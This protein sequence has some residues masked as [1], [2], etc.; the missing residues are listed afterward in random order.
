MGNLTDLWR[1]LSFLGLGV[2]CCSSPC[3]T[4]A[5]SSAS[6]GRRQALGA[7][8]PGR[9]CSPRRA[10]RRRRTPVPTS[11]PARSTSPPPAVAAPLDLA[12]LRHLGGADPR[13]SPRAAGGA[14]AAAARQQ[15]R[16]G[17]PGRAG[18]EGESWR[19][20]LD[21]GAEPPL[22]EQL[23]F[24]LGRVA[25]APAVRLEGSDERATWHPLPRATSSAWGART[26]CSAPPSS[27]PQPRPLP[28]VDLAGRGGP[29]GA[30]Q[31]EVVGASGPALAVPPRRGLPAAGP[32]VVCLCRSPRRVG[33]A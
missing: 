11:T 28:A 33:L 20:L 25:A 3:C 22:H 9:S 1:V 8:R 15:P 32:A 19:L 18:R 27:M 13:S 7:R 24:G 10:P 23:F 17:G 14:V 21:L 26:G 16:G 6:R 2:A 31:V 4:S 12:T 29:A 30:A 5:S